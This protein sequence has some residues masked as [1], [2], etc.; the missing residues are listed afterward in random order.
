MLSPDKGILK[1]DSLLKPDPESVEL[2]TLSG[3][4]V[5]ILRKDQLIPVSTG[6]RSGLKKVYAF[7]S[8][9]GLTSGAIRLKVKNILIRLSASGRSNSHHKEWSF[10]TET[11]CNRPHQTASNLDWIRIKEV[12][13]EEGVIGI[14]YKNLK[15]AGVPQSALA[16]F[17]DYYLSIAALNIININAL[18]KLEDALSSK[19]IEVMTLKGASLLNSYLSRYRYA[20]DGRPRSYGTSG[21]TGRIC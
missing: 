11:L 4:V 20:S 12:A 3:K 1:G 19:Q 16:S 21:R 18:E 9:H 6:V 17:R 5:S 7:L 15:D 2:S 14:L 13:S 8:L 10:V